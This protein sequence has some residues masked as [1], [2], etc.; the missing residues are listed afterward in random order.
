MKKLTIYLKDYKKESILGPFFKLVESLFELFVP[1]VIANII[2][3]GIENGDRLY[4]V[5]MCGVLFLL[6]IVGL[7]CALTAQYFAAKAAVGFT[8]KLRHA[9]LDHIQKLSYSDLDSLGASSMITRMT[10]DANQVQTG[11]NLLLRLYLRSPFIVFGSLI[12]AYTVDVGA[13]NVF[14]VTIPVLSVIVFGIMLASIPLYRKV[15]GGL[16]RV[17]G[18]TRENLL[19]VRVIRAF[20]REDEEKKDFFAESSALAG[21]QLFA[22]RISA[23]MNPLTYVIINVATVVLIWSGAVRVNIGSLRQGEVIALVNYMSQILVE[24]IKLANL[25]ITV[26]KSFASAKRIEAVLEMKPSMEY[27]DACVGDTDPSAPA[28]EF[29][30]A[31]IKYHATADE[32]ISGVSFKA[33]RGQTVGIIGGTGSGKTTLVNVLCRFYDVTSGCVRIDG[34]DV[35]EYAQGE[36]RRK[37][38]VVPQKA[39]LFRGTLR[40]NLLWGNKAADDDQLRWA[41]EVAQA[42][43]VVASKEKGLDELISDGGSNFSGGQRQRLCIARALVGKPE[44]LILDDSASALDYATDA[45]LRQS[46]KDIEYGPTVFIVSQ[47]ASSVKSADFIIV[48]DDGETVGMGTHDEL[49]RRCEVYR[50]IYH[51]QFPDAELPSEGGAI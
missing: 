6:G 26:T 5:K 41:L 18:I 1:L 4:V 50:E 36:L 8:A 38:G 16:D 47:R 24:L 2:D 49:L 30:S 40:D 42:E 37:I 25:I 48:L 15:Q 14:A 21:R 33:E 22:G 27:P 23:L 12:M 7:A 13:G 28:V 17:L 34:H 39:V 20:A 29:D 9:L 31:S 3:V 46:I 35:R 10:G 44:I 32:A 51:S 43:N 19:G 45:A 11:V